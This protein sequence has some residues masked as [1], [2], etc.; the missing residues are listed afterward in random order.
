MAA[1]TVLVLVVASS[2]GPEAAI[3]RAA[4]EALGLDAKVLVRRVP[5]LASDEEALELERA[6]SADAVVEVVRTEFKVALH[7]HLAQGSRWID[8]ELHFS[9]GDAPADEW[10]TVG[11]ALASMIPDPPRGA[12]PAHTVEEPQVTER[13]RVDAMPSAPPLLDQ[14]PFDADRVRDARPR[15][16]RFAIDLAAEGRSAF[17]SD[18]IGAGAAIAAHWFFVDH[19][20]VRAAASLR[21]SEV[22]RGNAEA[23]SLLFD[24][25]LGVA[26]RSAPRLTP[27]TLSFAA[28]IDAVLTDQRMTRDPT[29]QGG[30]FHRV[31]PGAD[32][33][34]NAL[35]T[36]TPQL[37]VLAGVGGQGAF[38][39]SPVRLEGG[40]VATMAPVA[41]VFEAGFRTVF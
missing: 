38:R 10:R 3:V 7:A 32:L 17:H 8:R 11:F 31:V 28:R 36:V 18:D 22:E 1:F 34:A 29:A 35:W 12:E 39:T 21:T 15:A 24:G 33:V 19:F 25:A 23:S 27:G 37:A 40:R 4:N 14:A 9:H 41:P 16:R 30:A 13:A 5:T 6:A 20:A 26:W 2:P